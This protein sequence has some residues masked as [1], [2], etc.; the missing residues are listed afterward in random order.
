MAGRRSTR[1]TRSGPSLG[2]RLLAASAVIVVAAIIGCG[3]FAIATGWS[4][5]GAVETPPISRGATV[6]ADV[7]NVRESPST[8]APILGSRDQGATV[9]VVGNVEAGFAPVQYQ[10]GRGWMA[11]EY[12]AFNGETVSTSQPALLV[13]DVSAAEQPESEAPDVPVAVESNLAT[14]P[15]EHWIDVN[16][17]TATVTL[18]AGDSAIASF[19]GKIGRDPSADGFYATAVGTYH[20]Y[21]MNKGLAP[22]PFAD[23]TWLSDWVGFDPERKNG[24]HSPVRD[25]FGNEKPWQNPATLGCVRLDAAAAVTVFEFAEIGMRVEVHD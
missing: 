3:L 1:K 2:K 15:V 11:V 23:D 12:L 20:V 8:A 21:S 25:E 14:E 13:S 17:T 16:R 19:A 9:Q 22:T 24:I 18:F 5:P 10:G 4:F 6:I 7:L